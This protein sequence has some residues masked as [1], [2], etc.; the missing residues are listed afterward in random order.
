MTQTVKIGVLDSG[1]DL[2]SEC[3]TKEELISAINEIRRIA[4]IDPIEHLFPSIPEVSYRCLIAQ[5]A[6]LGSSVCVTGFNFED[7]SEKW[8]LKMDYHVI[9]RIHNDLGWAYH[10]D[11]S[12]VMLPKELGN[13]ASAFDAGTAFQEYI[14]YEQKEK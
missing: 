14:R 3:Y 6:G 2:I 8:T 12:T 1:E 10:D 11:G 7:G 13:C 5:A 9:D 4:N